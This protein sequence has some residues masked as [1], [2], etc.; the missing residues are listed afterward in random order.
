MEDLSRGA[1]QFA[2]RWCLPCTIVHDSKTPSSVV[3]Y[4]FVDFEERWQAAGSA[5]QLPALQLGAQAQLKLP[6]VWEV[7]LCRAHFS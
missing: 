7:R 3:D 2:F 4:S 6:P 1:L 5:C